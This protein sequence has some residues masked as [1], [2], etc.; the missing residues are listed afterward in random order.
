MERYQVIIAYDG[1]NFQGFQ[2]QGSSRTVQAEIEAALRCLN[3][4]DNAIFYAGRTDT[5]VHA[6]GQVIAFDLKWE[7]TLDELG[8]ALNAHLPS[9]VAVR[10]VKLAAADFH[11]RFAATAR[12]YRYHLFCQTNR[13]PLRERYAWR[14]WPQVEGSLLIQAA[15]RLTGTHDFAAFGSPLKPEGTTIRTIFSADW[16]QKE[17]GWI[18]QVTANAFLYR[19]VRRLVFLQVLVGQRRLS[20]DAFSSALLSPSP[21]TPGL[22]KPNGLVLECVYFSEVGQIP[23]GLNQTLI[24]SGDENCG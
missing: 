6:S 19:M 10:K 8:R 24:A 23:E 4:Q 5:G 17:D 18:F 13:D 3:W 12:S 2:R 14:V 15:T 21:L 1:T 20:L 16:Q 11:P 22:A 7:H 9:D